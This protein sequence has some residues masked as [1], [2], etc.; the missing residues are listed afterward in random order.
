VL[1]GPNASGESG[2]TFIFGGDFSW[3]F[4]RAGTRGGPVFRIDGEYVGRR[5]RADDQID[6]TV[7]L[8]PVPVPGRTLFDQGFYLQGL[9]GF[10]E[11]WG[12]GARGEWAGG[13]HASYD[14]ASQ[15]FGRALDPFRADRF[16][17]SPLLAWQ[18][19]ESSRIRLQYNYDDGDALADPVHSVWLG[20]EVRIGVH[21][22]HGHAHHGHADRVY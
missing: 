3:Q 17:V 15:T 18:P 6:T 22:S 2:D 11:G 1:F 20:F 19:S 8:A 7:P 14:Q 5:W 10:T 9:W 16:R 4:P 21:R 13:S 12:L